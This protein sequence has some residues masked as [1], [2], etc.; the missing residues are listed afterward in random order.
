MNSSANL[1]NTTFRRKKTKGYYY[2]TEHVHFPPAPQVL[3]EPDLLY[4]CVYC[5]EAPN[6]FTRVAEREDIPLGP[7]YETRDE[8][9]DARHGLYTLKR[10]V[11]PTNREISAWLKQSLGDSYEWL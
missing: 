5:L 1:H 11:A 3:V 6:T 10:Y 8:Y 2:Y 7:R 4:D 9:D